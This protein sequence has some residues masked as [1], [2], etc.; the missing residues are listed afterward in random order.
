M[1]PTQK[2]KLDDLKAQLKVATVL[3]AEPHPNADKLLVLKVSLGTEE[4]QIVAGV[5]KHY[6]PEQIVGKQIVVVTNLES[7]TLRGVQSD[8]MLLAASDDEGNLALL[9]P[10]KTI[11]AGSQVK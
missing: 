5:K 11:A 8:G 1:E 2:I 3:S 10:D 6:T 4:R 7:A 9:T